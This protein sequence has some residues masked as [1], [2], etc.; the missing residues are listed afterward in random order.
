MS[1][2]TQRY[3]PALTQRYLRSNRPEVTPPAARFWAEQ[4]RLEAALPGGGEAEVYRAWDLAL[5]RTV[6]VKAY[7]PH[8][9]PKTAVLTRLRGVRHPHWVT[10]Y[11]TGTWQGRFYEVLEWCAGGTL[12]EQ[13]PYTVE[14]LAVYLPAMTAAL[15]ACHQQGVIH[16]DIKPN[17]WLFREAQRQTVLLSDFGISSVLEAAH[18]IT[19]NT[20]ALTLDYAAPELLERGEIS[21]KTDYYALGL[22]LIHLLQGQSPF[23]GKPQ[24]QIMAAHLQ[25]RIP[26]PPNLPLRWQILLRGLTQHAPSLR[27]G[28]A[29]IEAWRNGAVLE[30]PPPQTDAP[31]YPG[32]PTARSPQALAEYLKDFDAIKQLRR[33]DIRRW[34][35]DHFDAEQAEA[36]AALESLAERDPES[37][38]LKLRYILNPQADLFLA[39]M[40]IQHPTQWLELLRDPQR[41]EALW[42]ALA[43]GLLET[44][45]HQRQP[46]PQSA[47]L[48]A[49]L[50]ALRQRLPLGQNR[51][52]ALMALRYLLEPQAPLA[53]G[54]ICALKQLADLDNCLS[55]QPE[56]FP[57]LVDTIR[58]GYLDEWLR[59]RQVSAEW[60]AWFTE[61]WQKHLDDPALVAHSLRW[62]LNPKAPFPFLGRNYIAPQALAR[63]MDATPQAT[64]EGLRLL[65]SGW[66]AAWLTQTGRL[67]DPTALTQLLASTQPWPVKFETLLQ[68]LNPHLPKPQLL[69]EPRH[70]KLGLLEDEYPFTLQVINHKRGYLYGT[71]LVHSPDLSVP[72]PVFSSVNSI[73]KV[74]IHPER[75]RQPGKQY[76]RLTLR[77][78]GG[79]VQVSV[80][81]QTAANPKFTLR[82]FTQAL[83][84]ELIALGRW[85]RGI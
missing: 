17:N 14:Q 62:R 68:W 74:R 64:A 73:V 83:W 36:L 13:A 54:Q 43:S 72:E 4:Y 30:L 42:P 25:N 65:E 19:R 80:A 45:L 2:I 15:A 16:R 11:A 71:V 77:S 32:F 40:H 76:A 69:V 44:W 34:V 58:Q 39:G 20:A 67:A 52:R 56:A 37:A 81:Y 27:L 50:A 12:A 35:F 10:L 23:A 61:T 59:A 31:P 5:Q 9:S 79:Q 8:F 3:P 82:D 7:Y 57:F 51:K 66:L 84:A 63:A 41:C 26:L 28:A 22:T 48:A 1:V 70:I 78:N 24:A 53:L 38:L 47:E 21:P 75:V 46:I 18:G 85:L 55:R 49:A 60:L 29:E 33:G 6:V